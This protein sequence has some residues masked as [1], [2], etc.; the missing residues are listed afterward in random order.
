ARLSARLKSACGFNPCV[1]AQPASISNAASAAATGGPPAVFPPWLNRCCVTTPLLV[2]SPYRP[3]CLSCYCL[4]RNRSKK[5]SDVLKNP[6]QVTLELF[7]LGFAEAAQ[8]PVLDR[9]RQRSHL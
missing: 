9:H 3:H 8:E 6:I 2:A 7:H 4:G 5:K 1:L